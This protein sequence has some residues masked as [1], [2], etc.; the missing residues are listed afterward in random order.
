M[1]ESRPFVWV[2]SKRKISSC[3]TYFIYS[4]QVTGTICFVIVLHEK[5]T[6]INAHSRRMLKWLPWRTGQPISP[7]LLGQ[8]RLL[9]EG[10]AHPPTIR[11]LRQ[12]R[13]APPALP[14]L[15]WGP[16]REVGFPARAVCMVVDKILRYLESLI[17]LNLLQTNQ[18]FW[19]EMFFRYYLT[20]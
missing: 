14:R 6:K 15:R 2:M 4:S 13:Q 10:G 16:I 7:L 12:Q 11:Q 8:P 3:W 20:F 17:P 19:N 5:N 1:L 18:N 9:G